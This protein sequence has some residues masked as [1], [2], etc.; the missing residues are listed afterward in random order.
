LISFGEQV[1]A[2]RIDVRADGVICHAPDV[3]PL[4]ACVALGPLDDGLVDCLV[5][6]AIASDQL[7]DP[8]EEVLLLPGQRDIFE[9]MMVSLVDGEHL[10]GAARSRSA[11]T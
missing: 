10:D 1:L 4:G 3:G 7:G 9:P 11:R 2:S 5:E 8:F 6:R